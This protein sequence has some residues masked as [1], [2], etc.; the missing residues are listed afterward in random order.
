MYMMLHLTMRSLTKTMIFSA[1]HFK[2]LTKTFKSWTTDKVSRGILCLN[3]VFTLENFM[4]P[5]TGYHNNICLNQRVLLLD[6]QDVWLIFF[7]PLSHQLFLR[8][9]ILPQSW[10]IVYMVSEGWRLMAHIQF[11]SSVLPIP[12]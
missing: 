9:P 10:K 4:K 2:P 12:T 7:V 1:N 8:R 11:F 5:G 3:Y 6:L